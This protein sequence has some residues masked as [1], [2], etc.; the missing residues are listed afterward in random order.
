MEESSAY[1]CIDIQTHTCLDALFNF[2]FILFFGIIFNINKG[3]QNSG[4]SFENFN[5]K[6]TA[7]KFQKN[8]KDVQIGRNTNALIAVQGE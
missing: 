7:E 8:G 4:V 6:S 2:S 5:F 1:K 3:R